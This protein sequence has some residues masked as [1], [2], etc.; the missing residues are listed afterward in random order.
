MQLDAD[1]TYSSSLGTFAYKDI[2]ALGDYGSRV[3]LNDATPPATADVPVL[4][5]LRGDLAASGLDELQPENMEAS[6]MR[7]WVGL[8]GLLYILREAN[9]EDFSRANIKELIEASGPI[10]MLGLTNDPWT[11]KTDHVGAFKRSG[12]NNYSF[13]KWDPEATWNGQPGN[14]V[15]VSD[16]NWDET[17]CGTDFGGPCS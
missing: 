17:I 6:P 8:Y 1:L 5:V 11:P 14:F 9:A 15:K 3:I 7:S 16:A 10:P 4:D 13:W 2:A 12:N